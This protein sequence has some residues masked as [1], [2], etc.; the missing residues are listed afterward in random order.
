MP[1]SVDPLAASRIEVVRGPA[2]LLYGSSALG[3]VV[4]VIGNDI[5]TNVPNHIEGFIAAQG[6]TA[7]PGGAATAEA[8]FP[9]GMSLALLARGG[10]RNADDLRV[11]GGGTLENTFFENL[12]GDVGIGYIGEIFSGGVALNAYG[13]EY[14]LPSPDEDEDEEEG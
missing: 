2:S 11:G 5:P 3:G 14:G 1:G 13:F 9:L 6:E 10:F 4:N 12:H 8:I 7:T